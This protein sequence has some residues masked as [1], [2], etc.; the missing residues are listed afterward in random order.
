MRWPF[1]N[2]TAALLHL[3]TFK[4]V[5]DNKAKNTAFGHLSSS[6]LQP[7]PAKISFEPRNRASS[8]KETPQVF[9]TDQLISFNGNILSNDLVRK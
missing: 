6:D 9:P 1:S 8:A 7:I 3:M 4:T 5:S 2:K